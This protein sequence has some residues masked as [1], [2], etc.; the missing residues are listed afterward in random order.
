MPK[1]K[2][3]LSMKHDELV[4]TVREILRITDWSQAELGRQ[5]GVHE[6]TVSRWLDDQTPN[7]PT[8]VMLRMVL[9]QAR[10]GHYKQSA[11]ASA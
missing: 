6:A 7:R 9:E 5:V 1:T 11:A 2:Q 10:A 4:K 3:G 8:L